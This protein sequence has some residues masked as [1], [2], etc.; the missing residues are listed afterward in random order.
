MKSDYLTMEEVQALAEQLP[1]P[2]RKLVTVAAGTGFRIGDLCDAYCGDYKVETREFELF[3][4]K[5]CHYRKVVPL[6]LASVD[7]LLLSCSEPEYKHMFRTWDG[8]P[9]NRKS[10]WRWVKRAWKSLNPDDTR[11]ISPHSLRKAYAVQRRKNG[12]TLEQVR[13]DLGHESANTTMLYY[14]A[15]IIANPSLSFPAAG[16]GSRP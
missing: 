10:A 14:F 12:W 3:E 4:H 6:Q 13:A 8:K 9:I 11:Q 5:T 2:Y 7:I 16:A 15:D 1:A